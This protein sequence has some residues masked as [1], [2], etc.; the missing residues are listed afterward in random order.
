MLFINLEDKEFFNEETSV[1]TT[2]KGIN[3]VLE[4]SLI[5]LSKWE[6]IW[7]K[8]FLTKDEKTRDE[9]ISYIKLMTITQNVDPNIYEIF[10]D[11][12]RTAV[13]RY[14]EKPMTATRINERNRVANSSVITSEIIY[15]WMIQLNIPFECQKW[16][17]NRLLMLIRV[18]DIKSRAS[19]KMSKSEILARNRSLNAERRKLF[20]TT[21]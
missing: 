14:I 1:I 9:T 19:K 13:I 21:G 18:C 10:E 15:Y 20:N 3:L 4:H 8:P 17:L 6:A 11:E 7:E 16:N 12:L 2:I 5:S